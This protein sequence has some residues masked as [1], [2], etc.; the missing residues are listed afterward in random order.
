MEILKKERVFIVFVCLYTEIKMTISKRTHEKVFCYLPQAHESVNYVI[1]LN[2]V[3]MIRERIEL[4]FLLMLPNQV[5]VCLTLERHFQTTHRDR[6]LESFVLLIPFRKMPLDAL[7]CRIIR[8]TINLQP[9]SEVGEFTTGCTNF[10]WKI[11]PDI[12]V[13]QRKCDFPIGDC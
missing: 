7:R 6:S 5:N 9:E 8:L 3:M 1:G 13:S 2:D 10:M 12:G 4:V 11:N